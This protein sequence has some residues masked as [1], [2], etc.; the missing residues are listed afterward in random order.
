MRSTSSLRSLLT[1][2]FN[3]IYEHYKKHTWNSPQVNLDLYITK[4][5]DINA[6]ILNK[7]HPY[8][9]SDSFIGTLG[10]LIEKEF[11]PNM[12]NE[13]PNIIEIMKTSDSPE[14]EQ[15]D[16]FQNMLSE[17]MMN[18]SSKIKKKY[19]RYSK[20]PMAHPEYISEWREFYLNYSYLFAS[21][22]SIN[23][24]YYNYIYDFHDHFAKHLEM[25]KHAEIYQ[26]QKEIEAL[27]KDNIMLEDISS[28]EDY[29]IKIIE[30]R[31][32]TVEV[33]SGE[34]EAESMEPPTKK[35][36]VVFVSHK[37]TFITI[38]FYF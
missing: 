12:E 17:R 11:P 4:D 19:A 3:S 1:W 32:E 35:Q 7:P 15:N 28:G 33:S 9:R 37:A 27:L 38:S 20:N 21:V 10:K 24:K 29:D 16:T 25:R 14:S 2:I 5:E 18:E 22:A 31:I 36:K 26:K 13:E 6:E 8:N 34:E 23:E 30:K